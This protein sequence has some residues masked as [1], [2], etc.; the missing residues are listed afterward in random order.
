M[1]FADVRRF[2]NVS[3]IPQSILDTKRCFFVTV[4]PGKGIDGERFAHLAKNPRKFRETMTHLTADQVRL[5]VKDER[6]VALLN[7][8]MLLEHNELNRSEVIRRIKDQVKQLHKGE[9]A[10]SSQHG[11]QQRDDNPEGEG[12][13]STNHPRP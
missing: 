9:N 1:S 12:R 5:L 7:Q 8:L 3:R 4:A 2:V 6:D 13:A 11:N 10:E